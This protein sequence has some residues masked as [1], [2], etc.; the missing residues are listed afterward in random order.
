[1][2]VGILFFCALLANYTALLLSRTTLALSGVK[3]S[4]YSD[5]GEVRPALTRSHLLAPHPHQVAFGRIGRIVTSLSVYIALGGARVLDPPPLPPSLGIIVVYLLLIGDLM[6]SIVPVAPRGFWTLIGAI[7]VL[8]GLASPFSASSPSRCPL[9]QE[10]G[11]GDLD[12]LCRDWYHHRCHGCGNGV[13]IG[14][15]G[16][17]SACGHLCCICHLL[18]LLGLGHRHSWLRRL[19]LLPRCPSPLPHPRD[20]DA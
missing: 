6:H 16:L 20:P 2:G 4:S 9:Y 5:L 18:R 8:P 17:A 14:I 3:I 15:L 11:R 10:H 19:H 7:V 12:R 13:I 1:M